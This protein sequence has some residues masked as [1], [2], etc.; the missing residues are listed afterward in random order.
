MHL[1]SGHSTANMR[2]SVAP[3]LLA[4]ALPL[5]YA[6]V[7][8]TTPAAGSDVPVGTINV[9]W[10]DSGLQ[11]PIQDLTQYTLVLMVGGNSENNSVCLHNAQGAHAPPRE[12]Q[13]R[14]TER[15][16]RIWSSTLY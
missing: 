4:F 9:A 5:V 6:D 11:P 1:C 14:K 3:L 10:K 8:F 12:M 15:R 13:E 2:Q 16:T 7:E